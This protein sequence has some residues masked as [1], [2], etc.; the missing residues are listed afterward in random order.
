MMSVAPSAAMEVS[1]QGRFRWAVDAVLISSSV[2]TLNTAPPD[3]PAR[4]RKPGN[5]R[6][7]QSGLIGEQA[8]QPMI[9]HLTIDQT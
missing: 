9:L 6:S 3:W 4:K 7:G 5:R 2:A 1:F 8:S